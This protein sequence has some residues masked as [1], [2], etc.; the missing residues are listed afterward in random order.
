MKAALIISKVD[1][2]RYGWLKEQLA[3][4][5]CWVR[6][7]TRIL[8]RR[9]QGSLGTIKSHGTTPLR[10]VEDTS[11]VW[12]SSREED[13]DGEAAAAE[14]LAEEAME[15]WEETWEAVLEAQAEDHL[16][17]QELTM[18]KRVTAKTVEK[19]ATGRVNAPSYPQNNKANYT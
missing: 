4:T 7:S 13:T 3:K 14:A 1:K 5:I 15:A 12:H 11:Q 16:A 2:R 6:T 9:Q 8:W 19:K 10:D 17:E 18:H